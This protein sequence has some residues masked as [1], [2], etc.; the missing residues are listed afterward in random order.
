MTYRILFL[1]QH[2]ILRSAYAAAVAKKYA[3]KHN[4]D[5]IIEFGGLYDETAIGPGKVGTFLT[6]VVS[7]SPLYSLICVNET[8]LKKADLIYVMTP[9]MQTVLLNRRPELADKVQCLGLPDDLIRSFILGP[10]SKKR[11][12]RNLVPRL[13]QR[14]ISSQS[15]P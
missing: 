4:Q 9:G 2:G 12:I 11:I 13:E 8:Q 3:E 14:V 10:N 6:K 1:C 7:S 5:W 15:S